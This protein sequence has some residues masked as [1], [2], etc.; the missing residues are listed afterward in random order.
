MNLKPETENTPEYNFASEDIDG[1][2]SDFNRPKQN[3]NAD[4][5]EGL[6]E[7][8]PEDPEYDPNDIEEPEHMSSTAAKQTSSIVVTVIDNVLPTTLAAIAKGEASDYKATPDER[9][10]LK[11]ALA[12]YLKLKGGEIPP[13][14]MVLILVLSIYGSKLPQ[15]LQERK[16]NER[17]EALDR[18]EKEL[19]KQKNDLLIRE[20]R[21]KDKD[22]TDGE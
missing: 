13:W 22:N 1:F 14:L 12:E 3:M 19:E 4:E 6:D 17:Q 7:L 8:E 9:E 5:R 10:E 21:L 18:R 16:L 15:A 2:I 20:A 11:S